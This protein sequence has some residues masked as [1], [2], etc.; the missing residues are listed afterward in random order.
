[1]S[2]HGDPMLNVD[3]ILVPSDGSDHAGVAVQQA[4]ELARALQ[5]PILALYVVDRPG[6]QAFPPESILVDVGSIMRKEAQEVL[7]GIQAKATAAGVAAET[8]IR[9]GHPVDEICKEATPSDLIVMATHGRRG[10]SRMLLGSVAESVIRHAPCP[11][12]VVRHAA[13]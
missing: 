9:D 12:L 10:L 1:L 5:R 7:N 2:R 4:I 11:V 6:F 13:K 8:R 3:R